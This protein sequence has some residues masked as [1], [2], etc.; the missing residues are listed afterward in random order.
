MTRLM[1][2]PRTKQEG[3]SLRDVCEQSH[4]VYQGVQHLV[5]VTKKTLW[6]A[7]TMKVWTG[8]ERDDGTSELDTG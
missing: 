7:H 8:P 4:P 2:I 1:T 3:V 5:C 6:Q